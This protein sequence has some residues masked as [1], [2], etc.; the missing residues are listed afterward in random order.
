MAVPFSAADLTSAASALNAVTA[1]TMSTSSGGDASAGESGNAAKLEKVWEKVREVDAEA[2]LATFDGHTPRSITVPLSR[3]AA[4]A[5]RDA[6]N[7]SEDELVGQEVLAELAAEIDAACEALGTREV[8]VKASSRSPKDATLATEQLLADAWQLLGSRDY[9]ESTGVL[10]VGTPGSG[11]ADDLELRNE[12]DNAIVAALL[13]GAVTSMK[14]T[15][16]AAALAL[17]AASERIA[18]D[19]QLELDVASAR[20]GDFSMGVIVREFVPMQAHLEFRGF[21]VDGHLT[22]LSQYNHVVCYPAVVA[23]ADM[24]RDV[25]VDFYNDVIRD[26]LVAAGFTSVVIDFALVP[27]PN[28][29]DF[30]AEPF[31]VLVIE[32]NPY[33]SYEGNGTDACLF[34]WSADRGVLEPDAPPAG[35][36]DVAFRVRSAALPNVAATLNV[37]ASELVA[38][39]RNQLLS[40]PR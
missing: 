25:I 27:N 23:D 40:C 38:A 31:D 30:G 34:D 9:A 2:W 3:E 33:R 17:L 12:V 24:Y 11:G 37:S 1:R 29:A 7:A 36:D 13:Q 16:G 5:L 10:L 20:T 22:A 8:F 6:R 4:L 26:K 15:S 21:V 35:P 32:L 39:I 18:E 14:V 28:I 19:I